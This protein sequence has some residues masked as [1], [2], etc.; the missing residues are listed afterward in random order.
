VQGVDRAFLVKHKELFEK[1]HA[2]LLDEEGV[3]HVKELIKIERKEDRKRQ[4]EKMLFEKVQIL[5]ECMWG[6]LYK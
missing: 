3:K 4:M 1:F 5:D 6:C 2:G